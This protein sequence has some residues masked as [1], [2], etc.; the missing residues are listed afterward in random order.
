MNDL[1]F[2]LRQLQK[3]PGFT[4]VAVMILATGMAASTAVFGLVDAALYRPLGGV[5]AAD[6]L[7][8]LEIPYTG[9]Q[10]SK[11]D[12]EL[13][14]DEAPA[15]TAVA[16]YDRQSA[17]FFAGEAQR[18]YQVEFVSGGYFSLLGV[19]P[20]HGRLL[21][22]LDR[23]APHVVISDSFWRSQFDGDPDVVGRALVVNGEPFTVVGVAGPAF[24]GMQAMAPVAAWLSMELAP[25]HLPEW[26][27][28]PSQKWLQ[29][30]G[31]MSGGTSLAAAQESL[32]S[33]EARVLEQ[34]MLENGR[35]LRLAACG[36]GSMA[37]TEGQGIGRKM[38][39][40][41]FTV[42]VLVLIVSCANLASL[43]LSRGLNRRREIGI[44]LAL[45]ATRWRMMRQFLSETLL[46]S[47]AG[48]LVGLLFSS[49]G[50]Q[51]M[52]V[53]LPGVITNEFDL[54]IA[55]D[56]RIIGYTLA[57][58]VVVAI[59]CGLYPAWR[60]TTVDCHAAIK[61]EDRGLS[62]RRRWLDVRS[63]LVVGQVAV[64]VLLLIGG[65]LL[66]RSLHQ[67]QKQ[68]FAFNHDACLVVAL[69]ERDAATPDT[70]HRRRRA[71][72]LEAV[73]SL[74]GVTDATLTSH[75][76]LGTGSSAT[77]VQ[78]TDNRRSSQ[79]F[80]SSISP[81]FFATL[82]IP[83]VAGRDFTAHD[84]ERATDVVVINKALATALWPEQNPL[85]RSLRYGREY[86]V[87]GVVGDA[88]YWSAAEQPGA[89]LYFLEGQAPD[90]GA[91]YLIA[92]T[93]GDAKLVRALI[94]DLVRREDPG[95]SRP[96]VTDYSDLIA[97]RFMFQR[98]GAWVLGLASVVGLTLAATGLYGVLSYNIAQRT[99][100]IGVRIAL[101]A[102]RGQ[103][104]GT[105]LTRGLL[106]VTGG[107]VIGIGAGM[108]AGH[109]LRSM[110]HQTSPMDPLTVTTV[111]MLTWAVALLACWLPARRAAKVDPMVA[112]RTE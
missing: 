83:L 105:M 17:L 46:L 24:G 40:F 60:Q 27:A 38:A 92:R 36:R 31:R 87:I 1:K 44:R 29:L 7:V 75:P 66:L 69:W 89:G 43:L 30:I 81:G 76:P 82:K 77:S 53:M 68:E 109:L 88:Y 72:L 111:A 67:L 32:R 71:A 11:N 96:Y 51:A 5:R 98:V 18:R 79:S 26:I 49:W 22:E 50:V 84:L 16:G 55:Y 33:L 93:T 63:L 47:L 90:T 86:E 28:E 95:Q 85:G 19:Q 104:L 65:G 70:E 39:L 41:L 8:A 35:F 108:A 107:I 4:V 56:W 110:L 3:N 59:A 102:T 21:D 13:L 54:G 73:K 74:P 34:W 12:L 10:F 42:I 101:G 52:T 57:V 20:R 62:S 91:G 48:G 112:L 9:N 2:A 97:S 106:L 25:P 64:C 94:P 37:G 45:G 61:D 6:Q 99:R 14:K 80:F 78:A 103:I 100:E 58:S 23:G 15:F